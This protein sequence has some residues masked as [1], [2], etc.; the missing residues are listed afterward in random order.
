MKTCSPALMS[1]LTEQNRYFMADCYTLT[2]PGGAV[3]RYTSADADLNVDTRLFLGNHTPLF[4]RGRTRTVR[5]LEVDSLDLTIYAGTAHT[6]NGVPWLQAIAAGALDNARIELERAF[7][8]GPGS[9]IVG[10]LQLFSGRVSDSTIGS[11]EARLTVRSDLELLNLRF[12]RNLYQAGCLNLLFDTGCAVS[13]AAWANNTSVLADSTRS[14]IKCGLTQS[15]DYFTLGEILCTGGQNA[16]V[17]RSIR[18]YSPG[19][20]TL[21]FPL[22]KLPTVGD[23]FTVYPGCDGRQDTCTDKFAN[24]PRYRA[25]PFVPTPETAV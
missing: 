23:N 22:P 2:L 21:S 25:F 19:E 17:I 4:E 24:L 7:A 20:I 13:K 16:G 10:T 8:A 1:L 11:A 18:A 5:G 9:A 6:V 3:L 14:I 15:A 12:P